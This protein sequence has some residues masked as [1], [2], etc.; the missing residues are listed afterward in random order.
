MLGKYSTNQVTRPVLG[1]RFSLLRPSSLS[2]FLLPR[3]YFLCSS[4]PRT[5]MRKNQAFQVTL[6]R[7][8]SR[9]YSLQR[10]PL[11]Q[12]PFLTWTGQTP[13]S[14]HPSL[15]SHLNLTKAAEGL[16]VSWQPPC[17]KSFFA[18]LKIIVT[19]VAV[20]KI[21]CRCVSACGS[22]YVS[23]QRLEPLHPWRWSYRWL[24]DI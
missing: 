10:K 22:L 20:I 12:E 13:W 8:E 16:C 19:V 21:M 4:F 3:L 7:E 14:Q 9:D 23:A 11:R 18:K 5:A 24:G 15:S 6:T 17:L 2:F 1:S